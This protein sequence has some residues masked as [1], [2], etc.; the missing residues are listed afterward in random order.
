MGARALLAAG[1]DL[2]DHVGVQRTRAFFGKLI[3]LAAARRLSCDHAENLRDDV[4]GT[5]DRHGIAD[6]NVE[7]LDL[8]LVVQGGVLHNHAADRHRLEL[9]DRRQRAGAADLDL[10]VLEHGG[11][12]LGGKFMRDR[13]ARR[14]RETKPSRSCQSSRSTL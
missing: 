13:P 3:R 1:D 12:V 4:A 7:P 5:L 8:F 11:R 14:L 9:G 10:D 2:A 6:A